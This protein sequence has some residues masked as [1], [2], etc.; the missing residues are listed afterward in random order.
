MLTGFPG[1]IATRLVESMA[2]D[3]THFDLLVES[4]FRNQ[5]EKTVETVIGIKGLKKEHFRIVEG[6]ITVKRLGIPDSECERLF[7]SVTHIFHLA[8]IYDLGVEQGLA[9]SV[10]VRGTENVNEFVTQFT[11]LERYVYISTCYVAGKRTG[12]ILENELEHDAGFRNFYEET[13]YLAE[14]SVEKLKRQ[15]PVTIVRPAVVVGDSHTG[16]TA[17]YD[18]IYYLIKYLLK[19]PSLL[20]VLNVG[21]DDVKLNLVPVD[22]VVEGIKAITSSDETIGGTYALADPN[23]LTTAELF[24]VL[25][26]VITRKRSVIT[27]PTAPV[28]IFLN[29]PIS[30][31]F[32]GL[33]RYGAPYF[34]IS[35][36]YDCREATKILS[37]TGTHCP[38]FDDYASTLIDFVKSH[39]IL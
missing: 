38:R 14:M 17:K 11:R 16:E 7:T 13:K 18:G 29:S 4:R 20:R 21:N 12:R 2:D 32:T 28:R 34:F 3:H 25:A 36:E 5:A 24:D 19:A 33:P 37:E 22:F 6:D 10:N 39:P 31:P 8:A 35:Q 15:L 1:F 26:E 27:P 30:P 23:P 9:T